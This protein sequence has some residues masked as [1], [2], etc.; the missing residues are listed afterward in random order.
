[1]IRSISTEMACFYC[2]MLLLGLTGGS[3]IIGYLFSM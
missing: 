3:Y 1:M 2:V